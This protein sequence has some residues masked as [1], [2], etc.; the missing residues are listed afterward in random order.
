MTPEASGEII[1][2]RIICAIMF[3]IIQRHLPEEADGIAQT[4]EMCLNTARIY[5]L[6]GLSERDADLIRGR[7]EV[8]LEA[9][10]TAPVQA[11]P[12]PDA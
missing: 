10:F 7:A 4:L 11:A 8:A 1:A 6:P 12:K 9:M 3:K 5:P 2:L